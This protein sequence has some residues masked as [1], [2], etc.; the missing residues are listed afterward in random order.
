VSRAAG[1]G[2]TAAVWWTGAAALALFTAITVYLWPLRPGALA[3]QFAHTPR[4]FAEIVHAWPVEHL[5]RYRRHLPADMLLLAAYGAFGWLA[6]TRTPLFRT[7][8]RNVRRALAS[9]LPLAAAFDLAENALHW[10]LT[11]VPRFGVAPLYRWSAAC[12][13]AKWLLVLAFAVAALHAAARDDG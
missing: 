11:E 12:A 10:W 13:A 7:H 1:G 3:L 8:R 6:A 4:A 2:R 9:L 5:A